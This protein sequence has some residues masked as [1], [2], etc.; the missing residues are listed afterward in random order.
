VSDWAAHA[1][2]ELE[3]YRDGEGRLPDL[4]DHDTR[5]RQLTRMGNAAAGA[6]IA[7]LM[8]G[9]T[10]RASEWFAKAVERYRESWE[11]APPG[12]W[13][14]P[15]GIL[16]AEVLAGDWDAAA[17]DAGWTLE[18][19]AADAES[20]IGRYAACL[21]LLVLARDEEARVLADGLRTHDDFPSAVG[22]ALAM[23]AAQDVVG[24]IEA[25][26]A[27][28]ESFETRDEYLEDLPVADTVMVLQELAA[29]RGM[30]AELTSPL[31][32]G[33]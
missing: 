32:P 11:H 19:G 31:L 6:G 24:Y 33:G 5:Q 15:I 9:N 2:R 23:L 10:G 17:R 25:I 4:D 22:D 30:K 21:A 27:V 18:Q 3:R 7:E 8:S 16:K 12:S 26:E 13:G 14:R 28:L 29:R 20:P 1:H